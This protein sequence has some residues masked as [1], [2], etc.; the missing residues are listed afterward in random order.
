MKNLSPHRRFRG[1]SYVEPLM[2]NHY[3]RPWPEGLPNQCQICG[4]KFR[5]GWNIEIGPNRIGRILRKSA[6]LSILPCMFGVFIL[7]HVV[8]GFL[9]NW[10]AEYGGWYVLVM[11]FTPAVLGFASLF[12]PISRH[13]VCKKCGWNQDYPP[14]N[15]TPIPAAGE[16]P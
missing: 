8:G 5:A 4:T 2:H 9:D 12:A 10:L 3:Q 13:L 14:P 11:L 7:P 16:N 1:A 15:T 6:K